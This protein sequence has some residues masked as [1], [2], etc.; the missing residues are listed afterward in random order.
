LENMLIIQQYNMLINN[1]INRITQQIIILDAKTGATLKTNEAAMAKMLEDFEYMD[2]LTEALSHRAVSKSGEQ[3]DL[4]IKSDDQVMNLEVTAHAL[5]W[6][7]KDAILYTIDDV[8]KTT[9]EIKVLEGFAYYDSLTNL[10][11]RTYG[12]RTLNE[13]LAEK[14]AFV[15]LFIDLDKLKYINDV[16]GHEEGDTYIISAGNHLRTFPENAVVCRLG[17]DEFMVLVPDINEDEASKK[18]AV[19]AAA[20]ETD[21]YLTNK[22]F[23]YGMS[24]GCVGVTADNTQEARFILA[25]ADEKMYAHKRSRKME[26]RE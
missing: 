18:A 26:R 2:N 14:R 22:E 23:V 6:E 25:A 12:M 15:L 9:K 11:N 16:F 10:Y 20:L 13:W 3:F 19:I 21:K 7:D 4:E 1:I 5:P 17:G 24:Y 8:S